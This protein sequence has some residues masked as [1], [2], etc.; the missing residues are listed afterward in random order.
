ML[1]RE[2]NTLSV[3]DW[4]KAE[5]VI[6]RICL[7]E[8]LWSSLKNTLKQYPGSVYWHFKQSGGAGVIEITLWPASN[9]LW[10]SVHDNRNAEWIPETFEKIAAELAYWL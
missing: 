9:R 5:Q 2:I 1:E 8:G 6:E 10:L 4:T 3:S 7:K